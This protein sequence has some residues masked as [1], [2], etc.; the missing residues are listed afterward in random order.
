ME[1]RLS[2]LRQGMRIRN[3]HGL[4]VGFVREVSGRSVLV[5]EPQGP[6]VFW[7]DGSMVS[8][9]ERGEVVLGTGEPISP[10]T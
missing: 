8:G 10:L 2:V 6:R 9:V 3:L 5:G 7:I 4:P 1:Q